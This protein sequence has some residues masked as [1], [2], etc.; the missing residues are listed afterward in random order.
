MSCSILVPESVADQV[1]RR[2]KKLAK[3]AGVEVQ[4]VAGTTPVYRKARVTKTRKDAWG[5]V[6]TYTVLEV[7]TRQLLEC[8]R[9]TVGS[10]PKHN[11]HTFI[12]KIVHTEAGNMLAMAPAF[13]SMSIPPEWREAKPTCD[14]CNTKR[15]RKDTFII[16]TPQG[17]IQRVGRNCLADFL[18]EDPSSLVA[19]AAFEDELRRCMEED[20]DSDG[21]WGGG[22]RWTIGV[23]H[24][25]TCAFASV[26]Q[27]GFVKSDCQVDGCCP[28]KSDAMFLAEPAP[29]GNDRQS[30]AMREDW[31]KRQPTELHEV[32]TI[33]ALLWIEEEVKKVAAH[34]DYVWNLNVALQQRGIERNN[35]GL[36]A[37][38][39]AAYARHLGREAELRRERE[40]QKEL[41]AS[42]HVGTK[43]ERL[44]LEVIVTGIHGYV[45]SMGEA[46][47][48]VKARTLDGSDLVTFTGGKHPPMEDIGKTF[49]VKGTVKDHNDF[50]GR[51]QTVLSRCVW[52]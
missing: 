29:K 52:S 2:L 13:Q 50:K 8:R 47:S 4:Y 15:S 38:L 45:S 6:E 7:D 22:C 34:N 48:V 30:V 33:G 28:T 16:Q 9:I 32:E 36:V 35:M 17:S 14:H 12:G 3:K 11:G 10:M 31:K 40:G 21:C 37:S 1:G 19:L 43:G 20:P 26:E 46:K 44:Q 24:Y 18:K 51:A 23:W 27:K 41:P 5:G 49:K 42:K 39:P 25:L